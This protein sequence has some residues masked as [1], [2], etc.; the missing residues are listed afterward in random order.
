MSFGMMKRLL[1]IIP[2]GSASS[3][4]IPGQISIKKGEFFDAGVIR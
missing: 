1:F 2:D 3:T 4:T